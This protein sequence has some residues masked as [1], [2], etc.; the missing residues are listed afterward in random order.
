MKDLSPVW[1]AMAAVLC[2]SAALPAQMDN[3]T[4]LSV[5]WMR[6]PARNAATDST[7]IVVYN[8]AALVRLGEGFHLNI[9]NQS[10]LRKP[11]HTYDLGLGAGEQSFGQAG[12]DA[13]LPTL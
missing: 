11:S 1:I 12:M 8:P 5:E 2:F 7:D 4:N 3:L 6:M 9:G 10:L 13:V